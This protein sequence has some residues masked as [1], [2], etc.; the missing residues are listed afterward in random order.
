MD[1]FS[2]EVISGVWLISSDVAGIVT[3]LPFTLSW[4]LLPLSLFGFELTFGAHRL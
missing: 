1:V 4:S 2:K 3:A